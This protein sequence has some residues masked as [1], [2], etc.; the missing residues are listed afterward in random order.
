[1][2]F[3]PEETYLW[4]LKSRSSIFVLS[5]VSI[6]SFLVDLIFQVCGILLQGRYSSIGAGIWCGAVFGATG[7]YGLYQL[8]KGNND[9]KLVFL[10]M[11]GFGIPFTVILI[12]LSGYSVSF[13]CQCTSSHINLTREGKQVLWIVSNVILIVSGIIS[14]A[15][16]LMLAFITALSI[17]TARKNLLHSS[18]TWPKSRQPS[19][20]PEEPQYVKNSE[21]DNA[22]SETSSGFNQDSGFHTS[23]NSNLSDIVKEKSGIKLKEDKFTIHDD[24][25][26]EMNP[27]GPSSTTSS[28]NWRSSSFDTIDSDNDTDDSKIIELSKEDIII[29]APPSN[30]CNPPSTAE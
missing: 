9:K 15:T 3:D 29:H 25:Q 22:K 28:P 12:G 26:T 14:L 17:K 21:S 13:V 30:Y 27:A 20:N 2:A 10:S 11:V 6:I 8:H 16:S 4:G 5:V 19:E 7:A 18:D 1:M 23:T 24:Y